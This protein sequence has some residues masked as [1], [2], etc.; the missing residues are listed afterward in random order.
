MSAIIGHRGA[1]KIAPENTL[2]GI[3]TAYD[4]GVQWVE[5]D[6]ILLGDGELVIHH[7]RTLN[8]CTDGKGE[9]LSLTLPEVRK[10]DA[11]VLFASFHGHQ[12]KGEKIPTLREALN[13][14]HSLDMGLNLEIKMHKH[15][16]EELTTRVL[17]QLQGH[18]LV[19]DGKLIISSFD[20]DVLVI[21]K[22]KKPEIPV[23][24]LFEK[25]PANWLEQVK[26]VSAITVHSNQKLLM[27]SQAAEVIDAGYELYCYTVNS[28]KRAVEL[29]SWGVSG[30][31]TDDPETIK[32]A[33]L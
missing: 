5:I 17:D 9:L 29:M 18:P 25:L 21:C 20:H 24:H 13:L 28:G 11:G 16:P 3:R 10:V 19:E 2:A 6:V 15:S 8:R 27:K 14:I 12:F 4:K 33:L 31:F 23:G 32:A 22:E 26:R 1:A 30:V 7:D